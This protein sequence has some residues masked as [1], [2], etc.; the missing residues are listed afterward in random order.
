MAKEEKLRGW[1][2]GWLAG[3]CGDEGTGFAKWLSDSLGESKE[4]KFARGK[5][6]EE[7]GGQESE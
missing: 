6:G 7:G 5:R 1:L 3:D 4:R 2:H